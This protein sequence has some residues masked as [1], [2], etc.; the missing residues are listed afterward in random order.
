MESVM[1]TLGMG[2]DPVGAKSLTITQVLP[3]RRLVAKWGTHLAR[4]TSIMD[5][6][7]MS[8]D[9]SHGSVQLTLAGKVSKSHSEQVMQM[10]REME[11]KAKKYDAE[12]ARVKRDADQFLK[13]GDRAER[14]KEAKAQKEATMKAMKEKVAASKAM[15][16]QRLAELQ[17]MQRQLEEDEQAL[18][19]QEAEEEHQEQPEP[20]GQEGTEEGVGGTG[21]NKGGMDT[22]RAEGTG[23]WGEGGGAG[24][25]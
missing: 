17:E 20:T 24:R 23:D 14:I 21:G 18:R 12:M 7:G 3:D 2:V 15:A 11:A 16:V 22:E 25:R 5:L 10:G 4:D 1:Q 19:D 13:Y 9:H 8:H 6:Q